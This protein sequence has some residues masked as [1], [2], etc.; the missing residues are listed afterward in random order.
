MAEIE[1]AYNLLEA[2][3]LLGMKVRT[4]RQW[5]VEGKIKANKISGGR[6]WLIMESEIRRLQ[7]GE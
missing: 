5:V 2:A 1:K 7:K 3:N 4:V 6:K